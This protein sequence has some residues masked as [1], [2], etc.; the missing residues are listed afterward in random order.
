ME[1]WPLSK[2]K[3]EALQTLVEEQL[4]LG[5]IVETTS[6]WNSPVFMIKKK[7][8]K[9]RMLRDLRKINAVMELMRALQ[10]GLPSPAVIP[11]GWEIII[12][13]LKVFFFT[14]TL[15][16]KDAPKFAFTVPNNNNKGLTQRYQW[17]VLPQKMMDSHTLCQHL[18][19][20]PLTF[21]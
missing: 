7:S 14:I 16:P 10:L 19:N 15:D 20:Q 2:E 17:T 18:I 13:D 8:G 5:H 6:L 4:K 21:N 1:Q 12:T 3:I 9:W 11:K